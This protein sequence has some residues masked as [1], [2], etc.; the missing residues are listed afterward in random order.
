MGRQVAVI[1][2]GSDGLGKEIARVL[3]ENFDVVILSPTPDKLKAA[4]LELQVDSE[5][6][7][8]SQYNQIQKAVKEIIGRHGRIDVLINNAGIWIEGKLIDCDPKKIQQV[9]A[10]NTLGTIL[11][12]Q[13]VL[14]IMVKQQKGKI[15]NIVSKAGLYGKAERS[16]Y[17]AS[18]WAITG[19]TKCL[20]KEL[21]PENI[22][23]MGIYPGKMKTNLFAN[24]GV[25][26]DISNALDPRVVAETIGFILNKSV[27]A[28]F[29]E[30][31]VKS[32]EEE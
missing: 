10:V 8:V 5:V 13:A 30:I 1:S 6:C 15:V 21:I 12:S 29:S 18:K 16:V 2:G 26:K 14:Q 24:A 4:A 31:E 28:V 3:R 22:E 11:L 32:L 9:L 17:G 25:N 20:E 7:D 27:D 23:V 19:F